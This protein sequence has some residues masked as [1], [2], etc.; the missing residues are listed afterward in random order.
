ME[1]VKKM[2]G[3]G[4][5]CCGGSHHLIKIIL[6]LIIVMM[7]FCFG[8]KLGLITGSIHGGGY[9]GNMMYGYNKGFDRDSDNYVKGMMWGNSVN[10]VAPA[11]P[12]KQ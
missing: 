7:I 9:R 6:K 2:C 5:K 11:A 10:S 4:G 8:F 1:E 12:A 3:E